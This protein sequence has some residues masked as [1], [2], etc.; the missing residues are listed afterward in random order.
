[1]TMQVKNQEKVSIF[2]QFFNHLLVMV[3][4][5]LHFSRWVN[6][7]PIKINTSQVTSC[8]AIDDTIWIQE[9]NDFEN[10]VISQ[11]LGI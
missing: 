8:V 9:R 6:P 1:M 7:A 10:E 4:C 5:R 2:L 11:N 3:N